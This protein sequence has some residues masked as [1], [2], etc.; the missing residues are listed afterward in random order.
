MRI[1]PGKNIGNIYVPEGTK[2]VTSFYA[3]ARDA[4]IFPSPHLWIPERWMS[5]T[6]EM[7]NMSRPFS[8]GPRNCIGKH[9]AEIVLYKTIAR[10]FQT[11]LFITNDGV[12]DYTMRVKDVGVISPHDDC[13]MMRVEA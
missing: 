10:L 13:F 4:E 11:C 9:L 3:T 7:R 12:D 5:A 2:V 6:S 8:M 1:S